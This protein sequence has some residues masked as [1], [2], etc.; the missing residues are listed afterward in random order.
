M[1]LELVVDAK[2]GKSNTCWT[3]NKD[4][5]TW[6]QRDGVT[7]FDLLNRLI[8]SNTALSSSGMIGP[9]KSLITQ[10]SCRQLEKLRL[11]PHL[12]RN[13]LTRPL[14]SWMERSLSSLSL[15]R[16]S[17]MSMALCIR[18]DTQD[19]TLCGQTLGAQYIVASTV[20]EEAWCQRCFRGRFA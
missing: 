19:K 14:N 11:R 12:V 17:S 7:V 10:Q 4:F 6:I 9:L 2:S 15:T 1:R 3:N 13:P 8:R 20:G 16:W 5:N 18:S